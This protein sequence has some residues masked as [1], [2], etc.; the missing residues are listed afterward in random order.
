MGV[1]LFS[2]L[3]AT[4]QS[5]ISFRLLVCLFILKNRRKEAKRREE[6]RKEEK[7]RRKEEKRGK[8]RKQAEKLKSREMK[9]G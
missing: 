1:S 5:Q 2:A 3:K 9:E 7:N 8:K 4:L 6:R